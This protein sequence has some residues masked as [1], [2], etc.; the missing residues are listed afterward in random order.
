MGKRSPKLDRVIDGV[1][2]RV[3]TTRTECEVLFGDD[4]YDDPEANV[5]VYPKV[6]GVEGAAAQGRL[7]YTP[8][9]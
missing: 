8:D 3:F 1:R 7:E 9:D 2:V 5:L 4:D 6:F